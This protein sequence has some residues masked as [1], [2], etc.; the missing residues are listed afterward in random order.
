[1]RDICVCACV[2][3]CAHMPNAQCEGLW[4]TAKV[5]FQRRKRERKLHVI[6]REEWRKCLPRPNSADFCSMIHSI[7]NLTRVKSHKAEVLPSRFCRD[8]VNHLFNWLCSF[9]FPKWRPGK[10]L[11]TFSLNPFPFEKSF[12]SL[13]LREAE[14]ISLNSPVLFADSK[15]LPGPRG[16]VAAEPWWGEASGSWQNRLPGLASWRP[17]GDRLSISIK[18]VQAGNVISDGAPP[19]PRL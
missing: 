8:Q 2:C 17:G 5:H 4:L 15:G 12:F 14:P 10:P 1:M 13:C 6:G 19:V 18:E 11:L 9:G 3:V 16:R 7:S